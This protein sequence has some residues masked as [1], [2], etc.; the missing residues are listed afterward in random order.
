MK[1]RFDVLTSHFWLQETH[2]SAHALPI[3][4]LRRRTPQ[5]PKKYITHVR[6]HVR[7]GRCHSQRAP[8]GPASPASGRAPGYVLRLLGS[9]EIHAG[10][11][12]ER[13]AP[14]PPPRPMR[15]DIDEQS[16]WT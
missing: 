14:R 6:I 5:P 4:F 12:T 15:D 13:V 7:E 9:D 16:A 8:V 2:L 1:R 11:A 3:L 10:E